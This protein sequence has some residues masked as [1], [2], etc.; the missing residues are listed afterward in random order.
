MA[1]FVDL[2]LRGEAL[3]RVVSFFCNAMVDQVTDPITYTLCMMVS[4]PVHIMLTQ[5]GVAPFRDKNTM[6]FPY[7]HMDED[8]RYF[9]REFVLR[10]ERET[11]GWMTSRQIGGGCVLGNSGCGQ[12]TEQRLDPVEVIGAFCQ[13]VFASTTHGEDAERRGICNLFLQRVGAGVSLDRRV[14]M[15]VSDAIEGLSSQAGRADA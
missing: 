12:S 2:F 14:L 6:V 5:V 8:Q 1:C 13:G 7:R 15:K 9:L 3:R 11:S 10:A 4:T